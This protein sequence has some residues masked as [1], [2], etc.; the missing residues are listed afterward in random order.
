VRERETWASRSLSAFGMQD[1]GTG[2]LA[3]IRAAIYAAM[4]Y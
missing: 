1:G 2:K 4:N 3:A